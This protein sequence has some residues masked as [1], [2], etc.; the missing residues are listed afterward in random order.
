MQ[1]LHFKAERRYPY[2][3]PAA[4]GPDQ[5]A[6]FIEEIGT[7]GLEIVPGKI[8]SRLFSVKGTDAYIGGVLPYQ[9]YAHFDD[10]TTDLAKFALL[11]LEH[12]Y[13]PGALAA[14]L[15]YTTEPS[16]KTCETFNLANYDVFN[17]LCPDTE[18]IEMYLPNF[19]KGAL[20]VPVAWRDEKRLLII[21]KYLETG[22]V[23]TCE[24]FKVY[25][26]ALEDQIA[27][28]EI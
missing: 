11:F 22:C 18:E 21:G 15:M 9:V 25:P 12:L 20:V 19:E 2:K 26:P 14:V 6:G 8:L 5:L 17:S 16:A 23:D 4:P 27:Q 24:G 13:P 7:G 28:L 3:W 10:D 1:L